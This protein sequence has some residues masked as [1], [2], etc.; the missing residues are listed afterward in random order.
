LGSFL[1]I[2]TLLCGYLNRLIDHDRPVREE[3][4]ERKREL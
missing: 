3:T 1:S 2:S 4:E